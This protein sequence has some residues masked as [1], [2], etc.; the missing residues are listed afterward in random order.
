MKISN[1]VTI[2]AVLAVSMT[3]LLAQQAAE[4]DTDRVAVTINGKDYTAGEL[5]LL[6]RNLPDVFRRQT[7]QM[8]NKVFVETLGYLLTAAG[9]AENAGLMDQEPWKTQLWFN[10]LNFMANAHL[11]TINS[12]LEITEEMKQKFYQDH[13]GDYEEARVSAIYLDYSPIPELAEKQGKK[14]VS[15]REAWERAEKLLVGLRNGADFAEM[16]KEHST[17]AGSAG[18]GGDLGFLSPDDGGLS[19]AVKEAIFALQEGQVSSPVKDG[20]RYYLFKVTERRARPYSEVAVNVLQRL[21][22]SLMQER[23]EELRKAVE[24]EIKEPAWAQ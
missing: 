19:D 4:A 7:A 10:Q 18:R 9:R 20:G 23:L 21:Q 17:D 13:L 1:F 12:S 8:S 11:A 2:G 22:S 3:T 14:A 24:I 16:A 15:E 5:D 6:R